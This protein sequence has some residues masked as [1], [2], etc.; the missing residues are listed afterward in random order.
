[1]PSIN[2]R[3]AVVLALLALL[4]CQCPRP[5]V[6]AAV[7][8]PT[9]P[10]PAAPRPFP[11]EY[12]PDPDECW[13]PLR[14]PPEVLP[15]VPGEDGR[16]APPA[17]SI[18]LVL[19]VAARQLYVYHQ[20][21]LT[22]TYPT[23]V[24]S[25]YHHTPIGRYSIVSKATYPTYYPP[26]G[27]PVPPGPDNP[28][29]SRWLGWYGRFGFHGTNSDWS[30]GHTVSGGCVRLHNADVERLYEIT[31]IGAPV[32]IVY[33]PVELAAFSAGL[34]A[35]GTQPEPGFVLSL[36]PDVYGRVG[37]YRAFV[38]SRL[39]VAGYTIDRG[40]LDWLIAAVSRHG[41]VSLDTASPVWV[42]TR[43]VDSPVLRL[44]RAPDV[45]TLVAV[46][47]F[48]SAMGFSVS[49]DATS[50]TASVNGRSVEGVVVADRAYATLDSLA[51]AT[52]C[53]VSWVWDVTALG[54]PPNNVLSAELTGHL[55]YVR[56]DGLVV[57]REAFHENGGTYVPLRTV[58]GSLGLGVTWDS[59]TRTVTLA[60]QPVPVKI[61]D[62]T[63]FIEARDLA[64]AVSSS[65][66]V[67]ATADGVSI[68]RVT[69]GPN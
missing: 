49:W 51:A 9:V 43:R 17:H 64:A 50:K 35:G 55:G 24:G 34:E 48:C 21:T 25:L 13:T 27:D 44:G 29:G 57:S 59:G 14:V 42:G 33:E 7:D 28:L 10:D 15:G 67:E 66:V 32:E 62:A 23:A 39:A 19:N 40:V 26:G 56:V 38:E 52:G 45:V 60:G 65:W 68:T 6:H 37:P 41:A 58:A 53:H 2:H 30:I 16:T 18:Y 31:P 47:P 54:P 8:D 4:V 11:P 5:G 63:S 3:I 69:G 20:G 36:H 1:M 61:V 22:A 46:R 12:G